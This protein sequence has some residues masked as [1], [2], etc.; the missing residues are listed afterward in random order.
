MLKRYDKARKDASY[1][2]EKVRKNVL[3]GSIFA[4]ISLVNGAAIMTSETP[5]KIG[6][7]VPIEL[8]LVGYNTIE[9]VRRAR[10]A[11][12]YERTAASIIRQIE[13][14]P[15]EARALEANRANDPTLQANQFDLESFGTQ[16]A[17]VATFLAEE[18]PR[19]LESLGWTPPAS[20][21][22]EQQQL[23]PPQTPPETQP[24]QA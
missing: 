14:G 23:P 4:G 15:A 8:G 9:G 3:W 6:A 1:M 21:A 13:Q 11:G 18:L 12:R 5:V 20:G 19:Q 10:R 17:M 22:A 16:R 2:H 24:P 7:M